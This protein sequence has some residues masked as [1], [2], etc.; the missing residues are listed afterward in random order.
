MKQG[1]ATHDA[2]VVWLHDV[3]EAGSVV[4]RMGRQGHSLVAEWPSLARLTSDE[5][6]DFPRFLPSPEASPRNLDKLKG[7]AAAL[8]AD[9][10]GDL[11]VHASAAALEDRAILLLGDSGAGKS[12][13]A[14]EL[15]LRRGAR[16]LAD[17]AALLERRDGVVWVAPSE[18][19]HY[20]SR[21][22]VAALGIEGGNPVPD[23]D[24]KAAVSADSVGDR[25]CPLALVAALRFDDRLS[26]AVVRPL[27][28]AD[29][30]LRLLSAMFRFNV[31]D[32]QQ[33]LDRVIRVYE[34]APFIEISRPH[35]LP[36]IV[37]HLIDALGG[38]R[39]Q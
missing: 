36:G 25:G 8:L 27:G 16:L 10:R 3:R 12:T 30:A 11:G 20:L 26:N 28:G 22:S 6:G 31:I 1:E 37:P 9:L 38:L 2:A 14:A 15:C 19:S 24:E 29:A 39:A 23:G 35:T 18:A 13:A 4:Y 5:R 7:V 33:E 17:D 21:E 34:Q 32:R